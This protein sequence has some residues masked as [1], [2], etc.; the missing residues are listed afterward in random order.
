LTNESIHIAH[1]SS[2]Y[3]VESIRVAKKR[4]I[5]VT[6]DVTPHHFSLKDELVET[7]DTNY[8]MNPPLRTEEDIE[9]LIEGLNDGTIDCIATDHAP[10]AYEDK[11]VEFDRAA[12]GII[13]LS[14]GCSTCN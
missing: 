9:K 10:H 13:G 11:M 7:F 3:S 1:I 5:K 4:K 6:A 8:K 2:K 12:N 14:N